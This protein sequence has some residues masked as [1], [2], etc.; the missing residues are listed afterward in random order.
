MGFDGGF[1]FYCDEL[2]G[3]ANSHAVLTI[4]ILSV[5]LNR[6]FAESEIT[7]ITQETKMD[8]TTLQIIW[9]KTTLLTT[10]ENSFYML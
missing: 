5:R 3:S 1:L 10:A 8:C 2:S 6:K 7:E 9:I 4:I